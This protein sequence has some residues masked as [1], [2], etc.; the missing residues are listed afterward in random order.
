M[1]IGPTVTVLRTSQPY[2]LPQPLLQQFLSRA[3][4]ATVQ[5]LTQFLDLHSMS[6]QRCLHRNLQDRGQTCLTLGQFCG[7][8]G[9]KPQSSGFKQ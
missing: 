8:K 9:L 3:P 1:K 4:G 2:H 5:Q 7:A 6:D